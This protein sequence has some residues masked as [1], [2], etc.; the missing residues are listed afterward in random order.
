M[1]VLLLG[2]MFLLLDSDKMVIDFGT[3]GNNTDWYTLND[4]VMGGLSDGILK[5]TTNSVVFL[6]TVSLEN[7]GG[8]ASIR[9][10]YDR[11]K[12]S[13]FNQVEIR[14]R[15]KG[16]DFAMTLELY[17]QFYRPYFKYNLPDT[18]NKW[19]VRQISL[20]EFKAFSLGRYLGYE[21]K[22]EN[23]NNI[24]RMGFISNEKRAGPYMIEID[25]LNFIQ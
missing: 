17:R 1:K 16:Y 2:C 8:F 14:Y 15:S 7:N 22:E 18:Q 6:G 21:L 24:I 19:V 9:S 3:N 10:A 25:Y 4:G 12:M 5:K 11:Y 13:K 23:K 20:D